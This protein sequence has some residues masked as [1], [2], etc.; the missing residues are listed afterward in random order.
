MNRG[1][2]SRVPEGLDPAVQ[3]REIPFEADVTS[4]TP[5]LKLAAVSRGGSGCMRVR[6][7]AIVAAS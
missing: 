7:R 1:T 4:V 6:C 3:S 2:E 5:F